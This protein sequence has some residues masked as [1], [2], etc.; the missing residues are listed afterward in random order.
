MAS[1]SDAQA[2][3]LEA[4]AF[5]WDMDVLLE[6]HDAEE[7]ERAV[8]LKSPLMGINNRN[9]KTFE[10]TLDTTRTLAKLVPEDRIIVAESGLSAPDD[11]ADLARY[12]ARTFLI[13]ESLMRQ[14]DVAKATQ[15]LLANP[16][17]AHQV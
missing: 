17:S 11:L 13:G 4:A 10:T 9:L 6:V 14:D 12:G 7:L 3:E 5:E 8:Q 15:D 2:A 1:V 16:L